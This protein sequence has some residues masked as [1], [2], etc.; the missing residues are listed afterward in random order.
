ML[1]K[2]WCK[3]SRFYRRYKIYWDKIWKNPESIGPAAIAS[4]I[5]F[6]ILFDHHDE[7]AAG[8]AGELRGEDGLG[9]DVPG[10]RG[11]VGEDLYLFGG[12]EAEVEGE[13][14]GFV[15]AIEACHV[16]GRAMTTGEDDTLT[17]ITTDETGLVPDGGYLSEELL[18]LL[19]LG[20]EALRAVGKVLQATLEENRQCQLVAIGGDVGI[21]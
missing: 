10:F 4:P 20:E 17:W 18:H 3:D 2:R 21:L 19:G 14:L 15:A 11:G 12:D 9:G 8:L 1:Y 7:A 5:S 16:P 13:R 6:E